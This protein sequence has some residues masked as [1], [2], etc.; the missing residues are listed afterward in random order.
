MSNPTDFSVPYWRKIGALQDTLAIWADRNPA[1]LG[2]DVDDQFVALRDITSKD[3]GEL[4]HDLNAWRQRQ[5]DHPLVYSNLALGCD[6]P[7]LE[8]ISHCWPCKKLAIDITRRWGL[9]V[10]TYR[11]RCIMLACPGSANGTNGT[12]FWFTTG[13]RVQDSTWIKIFEKHGLK[14]SGSIV[15]DIKG[16]PRQE[17][18]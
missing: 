16:L 6:L 8:S 15:G 13:F 9:V 3:L 18:E 11:P 5:L 4:A 17:Q 7:I 1:A 2:L 12:L 14:L 10:K